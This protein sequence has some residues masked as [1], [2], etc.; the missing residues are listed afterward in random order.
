[1]DFDHFPSLITHDSAG[2]P[3]RVFYDTG[4]PVVRQLPPFTALQLQQQ[5]DFEIDTDFWGADMF[6]FDDGDLK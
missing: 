5:R 1:M 4:L 2:F 6:T 3:H